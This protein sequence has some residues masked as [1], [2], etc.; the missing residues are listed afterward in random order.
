[1]FT[2]PRQ[3]IEVFFNNPNMFFSI[4]IVLLP[5]IIGILTLISWQAT[6]QS[7][8][9]AI[10][11]AKAL[12][13]WI[14]ISLI[15]FVLALILNANAKKNLTGIFSVVS[16]QSIPWIILAILIVLTPLAVPQISSAAQVGANYEQGL[17]SAENAG[18]QVLALMNEI[19]INM[20][21][22]AIFFVISIIL[23]I[24]FLV[25]TFF[26]SAKIAG[27]NLLKA[28]AIWII[29]LIAIF[30]LIPV[31]FSFF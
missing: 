19:S 21:V 6:P 31:L 5:A 7:I 27:K 15:I 14:I 17:I 26:V 2:Q 13:S 1:V 25:I 16:L 8:A 18:N 22:V 3:V 30:G 28:L 10:Q 9:I 11:I 24:S 4:I 12:A 23:L 29:Q 20:I